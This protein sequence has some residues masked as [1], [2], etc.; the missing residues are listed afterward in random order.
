VVERAIKNRMEQTAATDH[1]AYLQQITPEELTALVELVV[2][3]E[4]WFYRDRKPSW[5]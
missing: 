5:R 1:D 3:P 4:S 2:V